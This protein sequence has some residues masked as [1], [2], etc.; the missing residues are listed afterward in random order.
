MKQDYKKAVEWY[1][2]AAKRT[3]LNW[4]E[5]KIWIKAAIA[6]HKRSREE[7]QK[8][9]RPVLCSF[10]ACKKSYVVD[11]AEVL[12]VYGDTEDKTLGRQKLYDM[13]KGPND[14]Y[15]DN[16]LYKRSS[17]VIQIKAANVLIK[18]G[19]EIDQQLAIQELEHV[20]VNAASSRTNENSRDIL[21]LISYTENPFQWNAQWAY[22]H[23]HTKKRIYYN[24][25]Q[26]IAQQEN[27]PH[28][29]DAAKI[30]YQID[31]DGYK[32]QKNIGRDVL[33]EISQKEG[34]PEQKKAKEALSYCIIF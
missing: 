15:R 16:G 33:N 14:Y 34:H 8:I 17:P 22:A 3:D 10:I 11:I 5:E 7:D 19:D 21:S 25:M 2:L 30:L 31:K 6:L 24:F 28:R 20:Y 18:Y 27:H 23:L 13:S 29:Y 26:N 1:S 9:S 32:E 12:F 4:N